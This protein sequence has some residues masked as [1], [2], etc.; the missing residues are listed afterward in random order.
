MFFIPRGILWRRV[1]GFESA[2]VQGPVG[3]RPIKREEERKANEA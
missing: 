1:A 2:L 3:Q